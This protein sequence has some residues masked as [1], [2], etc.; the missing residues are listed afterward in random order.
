MQFI[1]IFN[2]TMIISLSILFLILII[3]VI[4]LFD[5]NK[6]CK[7]R[8]DKMKKKK[9]GKKFVLIDRSVTIN[10]IGGEDADKCIK[11]IKGLYNDKGGRL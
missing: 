5:F 3:G 10:I 4:S 7:R 11:N 1:D 8:T 6:K 2:I 9:K